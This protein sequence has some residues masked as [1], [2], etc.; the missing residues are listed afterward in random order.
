M[1]GHCQRFLLVIWTLISSWWLNF[2]ILISRWKKIW[3]M[4]SLLQNAHQNDKHLRGILCVKCYE[5]TKI[6]AFLVWKYASD[7]LFNL[8]IVSDSLLCAHAFTHIYSVKI[9][10]F[11]V[12]IARAINAW[13][14]VSI[15]TERGLAK[16][17]FILRTEGDVTEDQP[18]V[19]GTYKSVLIKVVDLKN[20]FHFATQICSKNIEHKP[21]EGVLSNS[22]TVVFWCDLEETVAYDAR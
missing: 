9:L 3:A 18:D 13:A 5:F 12:I 21:H 19:F 14:W 7:Q 17:I 8:L 1:F 6:D 2:W 20:K 22:F 11:T 16:L 10:S 15:T 4:Q